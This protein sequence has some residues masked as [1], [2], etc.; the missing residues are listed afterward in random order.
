MVDFNNAVILGS[1]DALSVKHERIAEIIQ[2]LDPNLELVY[3]PTEARSVFDKH[4]FGVRHKQGGYMALTCAEDEVD[5]RLVAKLIQGDT[6]R[7]NFLGELEASEA[8]FRLVQAKEKMEEMEEKREFA[9]SVLKSPKST[10]RHNGM[11]FT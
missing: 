3:I 10:Y 5:E 11:V 9:H 6:R 8:A 1:T 7:G 2:D 4:P